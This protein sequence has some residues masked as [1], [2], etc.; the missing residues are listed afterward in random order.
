MRLLLCHFDRL[1]VVLAAAEFVFTEPYSKRL[2]LRLRLRGEVL[3]G[4]SGVTLEQGHAVEF[5]VHDRLYN[6]HRCL[7]LL[8]RC[9]HHLLSLTAVVIACYCFWKVRGEGGFLYSH[10][11][12]LRPPMA[13]NNL[14]AVGYP[15]RVIGH[16]AL[17]AVCPCSGRLV[18][19]RSAYSA[20]SR[21]RRHRSS[22]R[23]GEE[24]MEKRRRWRIPGGTCEEE[25]RR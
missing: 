20:K 18:M 14:I 16:S 10:R 23:N 8:L 4:S 9:C 15:R 3:H 5:A 6:A 13:A 11:C 25:E 22:A 21:R 12:L 24:E 1:G 7:L 17:G 19:R 2:M